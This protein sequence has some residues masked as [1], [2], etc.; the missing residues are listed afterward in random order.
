MI[1]T[2]SQLVALVETG[3]NPW[4]MR[5]EPGFTVQTG[6]INSAMKAIHPDCS[7]WTSR[8]ILCTSWGKY[9]IMGSNLYAQGLTGWPGEYLADEALQDMHF[10]AYCQKA[11]IVFTLDALFNSDDDTN[12]ETF[13]RKWNGP[14]NVDAYVG[15]MKQV[16]VEQNHGAA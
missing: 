9:Q 1:T 6:A 2:L 5:Y 14:G 13:A 15:R 16:Y 10:L 12:L 3:N 11:Q 7:A 4:A 8:I